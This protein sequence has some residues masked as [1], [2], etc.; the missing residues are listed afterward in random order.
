MLQE[1][2]VRMS[3][4]QLTTLQAAD[5]LELMEQEQVDSQ[6]YHLVYNL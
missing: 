4:V 2:A 6:C 5:I 1:E 3:Q